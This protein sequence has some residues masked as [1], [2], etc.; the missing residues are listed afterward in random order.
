MAINEAQAAKLV[1]RAE[2]DGLAG[3]GR[4]GSRAIRTLLEDLPGY[5]RQ[6]AEGRL[7]ALILA[8]QLPRPR[9]NAR[10]LGHDAD[11]VWYAQR[12]IVEVDGFAAHGHRLAFERDRRRDQERAAAGYRTV[13]VTWRQLTQE[14]EA[15]A[16]MLGAA[17]ARSA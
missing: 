3:S 16:A 10:V 9:F 17:L 15:V 11:A 12:L 5:T 7:K 4:H 13:R 2:L 6:A 8:A 1:T 14:P